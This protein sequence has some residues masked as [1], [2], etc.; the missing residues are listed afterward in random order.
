MYHLLKGQQKPR[1][2]HGVY[3]PL[4]EHPEPEPGATDPEPGSHP[5]TEPGATPDPRPEPEIETGASQEEPEPIYTIIGEPVLPTEEAEATTIVLDRHPAPVDEQQ[6]EE[7]DEAEHAPW[8][9]RPP[10]RRRLAP[11]G[12]TLVG[13]ALVLVGVLVVTR[14]IPWWQTSATVTIVPWTQPVRTTLTVQLVPGTANLARQQVQGR[15]LATLTMSQS[16][17]VPAT[18]SGYQP[19]QA[20]HGWITLYNALPD[21][22]TIPAG[23]L[24]IGQDGTQVTT[25]TTV[26]IPAAN[27]PLEGQASVSAHATAPGPAGNMAALDINGPCCRADVIAKNP[28][29][30]TGGQNARSFQAVSAQ[31][32]KGA[33]AAL[34][35]S[36]TQ[37]VTAAYQAELADGESLLTPVSCQAQVSADHS[38]G[39]EAKQVTVSVSE[40][41]QGIAYNAAQM[42]TLVSQAITQQSQ[43]QGNQATGYQLDPGTLHI[44]ATPSSTHPGAI[45]VQARG[46]LRYHWNAQQQQALASLIAGKREAQAITLLE[47]QPGI[48]SVAVQLNGRDTGTLPSNPDRIHFMFIALSQ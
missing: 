28:A 43:A 7:P 10:L 41:C 45:Q 2:Y 15:Q 17:T 16:K 24:I 9:V 13:M 18:G 29:P 36:V 30:F 46:T 1:L 14:V 6:D 26:T 19:A 11:L 22:Q 20:A 44:Q 38:Q 47:Q 21:A 12:W 35:T 31:D 5:G 27:A 3:S 4:S 34:A 25:D 42:H 32:I 23:T 48:A 37:E 33:S 8:S 40:R 39:S